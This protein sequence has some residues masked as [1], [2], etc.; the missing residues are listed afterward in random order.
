MGDFMITA[1]FSKMY[2][3]GPKDGIILRESM[4]FKTVHD[5]YKWKNTMDDNK[6]LEWV[7]LDFY[8]ENPSYA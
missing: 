2:V 4:K 8:I 1:R 6:S 3:C 5:A 7:I